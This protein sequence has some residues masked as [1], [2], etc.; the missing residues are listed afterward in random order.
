MNA[1]PAKFSDPILEAAAEIL[2]ER[3][4]TGSHVLDPFA[5]T[6]KGVRRLSELGYNAFGVELEPEACD[7]LYVVQGDALDL[8]PSD[9]SIDAVFTSPAYGNR[10]ADRDMRPSVAGTYMKWLGREASEG[11]SCHLQWGD[12]YREF[13]EKAWAE[14]W[15]VLRPGG[16]FLL[17]I[18]DHPRNKRVQPVSAWHVHA[19]CLLGFTWEDAHRIDTP[20]NRKGANKQLVVEHEWLHAF[21][22]PEEAQ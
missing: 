20:G 10:M 18:K 6:G 14:V 7:E 11:S 12:A 3:V 19:I 17:N 15:R 16:W 9:A 2:L 21:R 4:A 22:K 8:A 1:H 13:H 5:G